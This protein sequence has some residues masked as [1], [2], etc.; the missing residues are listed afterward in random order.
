MEINI[1]R[2]Q[3]LRRRQFEPTTEVPGREAIE[4]FTHRGFERGSIAEDFHEAT[5]DSHRQ[6]TE[7]TSRIRFV[8]EESFAV[9][10]TK[11]PPYKPGI[12]RISLPKPTE[13]S[14]SLEDAL[15]NRRSQRTF[16]GDSLSLPEIGTLL[17]YSC[18]VTNLENVTDDINQSFRAYPSA[19]ALY[20][21]YT[22]LIILQ[23]AP[24]LGVGVYWYNPI[25]HAL[26][27]QRE[28]D[29][30]LA[31]EL[32]RVFD[33]A[34][35]IFD[36]WDAAA[37]VVLTGTFVRSMA[38]YG[39]LGYRF[40]LQESGH[41][42]QNIL[43]IATAIGA[44]AFPSAAYDDRELDELLDVDGVDESTVYTI[45]IGFGPEEDGD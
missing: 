12:G 16:G 4:W 17:G 31:D 1:R 20:P 21:I 6:P 19:G 15:A 34:A 14:V 26:E 9:A 2:L 33:P 39:S 23:E 36:L 30:Q 45:P 24:S 5:K 41:V 13:T 8:S 43:M 10:Q 35:D 37:V 11:L 28:D 38:K 22:H 7:I 42:A 3:Q 25:E 44:S 32:E 18:G 27:Q 29:A 40:A